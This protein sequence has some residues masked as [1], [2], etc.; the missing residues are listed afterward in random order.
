M[1]ARLKLKEIDGR[2][3]PGVNFYSICRSNSAPESSPKGLVVFLATPHRPAQLSASCLW[4]ATPS[5]CGKPL[6]S[7]LPSQRPKGV[8]GQVNCLGYGHN[9]KNAT[10]GNPHPSSYGAS[11]EKVQRLDGGGW[12]WPEAR[13]RRRD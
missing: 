11:T 12:S 9:V 13:N 5:N 6:K 7:S 3:P 8:G 2:A 10:M 4:A 1:V